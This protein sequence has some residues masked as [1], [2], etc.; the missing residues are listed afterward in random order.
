MVNKVAQSFRDRE[1][2]SRMGYW[3]LRRSCSSIYPVTGCA[4]RDIPR[5]Q[6]GSMIGQNLY[7]CE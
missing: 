1:G 6:Y 3:E 2:K 4:H 7:A 5:V